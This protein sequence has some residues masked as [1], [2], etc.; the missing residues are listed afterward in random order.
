MGKT[1]RKIENINGPG[2]STK[3]LRQVFIYGDGNVTGLSYTDM[4][5]IPD[6][7]QGR[8]T[9]QVP[10]VSATIVGLSQ[11]S[12]GI[13]GADHGST[14]FPALLQQ[15]GLPQ[16]MSLELNR[17]VNDTYENDKGEIFANI[18]YSPPVPGGSFKLGNVPVKSDYQGGVLCADILPFGDGSK[19]T[20]PPAPATV[21]NWWQY[22]V[23]SVKVGDVQ[24]Q[25]VGKTQ[26]IS[27]SGASTHVG[28]AVYRG[29]M[30]QF[31]SIGRTCPV[32]QNG[33]TNIKFGCSCDSVNSL[34]AL[35]IR[36][37]IGDF[38]LSIGPEV[39][40]GKL[41]D[42]NT[43]GLHLEIM[44]NDDWMIMGSEVFSK[45]LTFY[46]YENDQIGYALKS[47]LGSK[48]QALPQAATRTCK[49]LN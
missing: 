24:Q 48:H 25:L 16:R 29:L 1:A 23:D 46:D 12:V 5:R 41:P 6:T 20:H 9:A 38:E 43:C 8:L 32:L 22:E 4:L 11:L 15:N 47:S 49:A 31:R 10:V 3:Q 34:G 39:Y 44:P 37:T 28:P 19:R 45:F 36:Y 40:M 18:E 13:I 17:I 27:D 21:A 35:Q 26:L 14:T 42:E 33:T 2:D 7:D 30:D